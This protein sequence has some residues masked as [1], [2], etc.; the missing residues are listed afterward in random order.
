MTATKSHAT[1][2]LFGVCFGLAVA[3]TANAGCITGYETLC[4]ELGSPVET[5]GVGSDAGTGGASMQQ[6]PNIVEENRDFN[7]TQHGMSLKN[8]FKFLK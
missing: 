6:A 7:I 8:N 1:M 4:S 3:G 2:K 5:S